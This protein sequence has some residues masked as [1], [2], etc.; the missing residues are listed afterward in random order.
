MPKGENFWNPYRW[1]TVSPEKVQ[2]DKPTY[3]DR[4][5]GTV[6]QLSCEL[7]ALTPLLIG[8]GQGKFVQRRGG[9]DT[10]YI[11]STSLK[12]VIRSLAETISHSNA[13]FRKDG[14]DA[15][16][17]DMASRMFGYLQQGQVF[18]GLVRFSDA[19]M[20]FTP[21]RQWP[22]YDIAVGQPKKAHRAFYPSNNSDQQRKFYHH[23]PGT[24]RLVRPHPGITQTSN[25]QPAPGGTR[26]AFTVDFTNLHDPELDL[27]LYCLALEEQVTVT[28]SPQ[29]LGTNRPQPVTL[30]GPMRH[31]M[32]GAKPQ[33]AGSVQIGITKMQLRDAS[34]RYRGHDA[35]QTWDADDLVQEI[36]RRTRSFQERQD[37]TMR[38]LRAMMIYTEQDPRQP[39]QY[40]TWKWFRDNSST[41]L[42][43]TL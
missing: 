39:V 21:T 27:L 15:S 13:P 1:V 10:C 16:R 42:K 33:G 2:R 18:R 17:L 3:H 31:K 41:G 7:T 24:Q 34:A 20:T 19:Q 9:I 22:R 11:P 23:H 4:F 38:E 29:A 6:G 5:R 35:A 8:D 12:G 43:P 37:Q 30:Q 14:T 32:G 25:V 40:P 26:F 28:L 36:N